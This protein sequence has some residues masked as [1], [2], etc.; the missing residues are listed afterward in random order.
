[1]EISST[2]N[3]ENIFAI[4]WE[5]SQR[6]TLNDYRKGSAHRVGAARVTE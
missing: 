3:R 4:L 2:A 6:G 1:M 5:A